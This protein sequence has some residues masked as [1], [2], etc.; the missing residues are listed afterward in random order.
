[1]R[2][3]NP[4][5][6]QSFVAVIE[7]GGFSSAARI[8]HL[9]QPA[10]S[11]QIREL[12]GRCGVI[13]I[14]RDS[15]PLRLTPAGQD[16][17]ERAK[18]ILSEQEAALG[19]MRRH[20]DGAVGRVRAGMST[21]TLIHIAGPA[22]R[23][24]KAEHPTLQMMVDIGTSRELAQAVRSND[25]DLAIVT[26]PVELAQLQSTWLLDDDL[27]AILPATLTN[28]PSV[29]SPSDIVEQPLITDGRTAI[30]SELTRAWFEAEGLVPDQTMRIEHL[31]AI[32]GAVAAGLGSA[33]VPQILV[34]TS[35][36]GLIVR[37]LK[38]RLTRRVVLVERS[39][40]TKSQ[41]MS[42]LIQALVE[43]TA[44]LRR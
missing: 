31:E 26:L 6:L 30:L 44:P 11:L 34:R 42:L 18:R 8:L 25:L 2:N 40:A 1:M 19:V 38:P 13:L 43:T 39:G 32:K 14:D 7:S 27:V 24:V 23:K 10:I 37:P 5:Q 33:I 12:E 41:A 17:F 29:I 9:T 28:T 21:T 36:P 22:L 35:Q 15:R 4:D 20:R 3:L 16:L